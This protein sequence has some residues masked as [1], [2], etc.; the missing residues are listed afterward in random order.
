MPAT[1]TAGAVSPDLIDAPPPDPDEAAMLMAGLAV[2]VCTCQRPESLARLL[3]SLAAHDRRPDQLIIVDASSGDD[4]QRML[5]SYPDLE[6]LAATVLYFHVSGMLRGLTRQRNY[7]LRWVTTDLVAFFDDDVV[8]L[9][10][11]LREMER[12]HRSLGDQIAGVGAFIRNQDWPPANTWLWHARVLLRL[13]PNLQPGRYHRSGMSTPWIFLPPTDGLVEGDWLPGCAMMWRTAVAREIRFCEDLTGYAL[14]EDLDFSLR[15]R[16]RGRL[17]VTGAAQVLHLL[18]PSGRPGWFQWGYMAIKN[19]Y[20][21]HRRALPDRTWRDVA[22]F[23][24]AW[25]F[26]TLLLM[27]HLFAAGRRRAVLLQ[28]AGRLKAAYDLLRDR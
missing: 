10:G 19:K 22:W 6:Q 12:V 17:V 13:M 8:L 27:R 16:S 15:A 14:G 25:V 4:T 11:C 28:I 3:Q 9:P 24:Y 20:L 2:V 26:D 1:P 23:I 5:S 7:A 21:I 18:E